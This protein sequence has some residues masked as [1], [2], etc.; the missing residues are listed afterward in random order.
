MRKLL[1]RWVWLA[2]SVVVASLLTRMLGLG[3]RVDISSMDQVLKLFVGVA[4]LAFANATLGRLLKFFT[5]PLNCLTLGLFSLAINALV[6]W[7]VAGLNFGFAIV[8]NGIVNQFLAA[9]VGALLI[10]AINGILR[11][12]LP[13][14]KN[15]D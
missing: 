8:G 3:F 14:D 1:L 11:S 13:D 10:T 15:D 6:L 4:V 7:L 12:V 5:I 9:F 2:V